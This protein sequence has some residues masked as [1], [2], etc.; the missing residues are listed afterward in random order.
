MRAPGS[1][2]SLEAANRSPT[3]PVC[4]REVGTNGDEEKVLLLLLLPYYYYCCC[5]CCL[6]CSN[7]TNI[8]AGNDHSANKSRAMRYTG[9]AA[10]T[11]LAD[12]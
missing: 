8:R 6:P 3:P 2:P 5:C 10:V 4:E 7:G 9:F 12:R 1:D 11:D